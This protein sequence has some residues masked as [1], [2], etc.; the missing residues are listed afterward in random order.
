MAKRTTTR[1]SL[2][3]T[4]SV[5]L[6]WLAAVGLR[7]DQV[8]M[9]NGDRYVGNVLSL[10]ADKLVIQSEVLG[11]LTIPRDK[12][13]LIT[14]GATTRTNTVRVAASPL[15]VSPAPGQPTFNDVP[16]NHPFF[17]WI[18][19][20]SASGVTGGC[21][22]A[23]PLYCPDNFVTRGQMAVFLAKALGL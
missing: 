11:K 4:A 22:A 13:A 7:A 12:V 9:Q 3:G 2:S 18:E 21:N 6:L 23:P 19:A 20:L 1:L 16:T 10:T 8:E 14:L 17:Q 5:L 15:Q